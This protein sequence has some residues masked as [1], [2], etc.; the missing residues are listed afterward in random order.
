MIQIKFPGTSEGVMTDKKVQAAV[1]K[2]NLYH[3]MSSLL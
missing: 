1:S 3:N 2:F